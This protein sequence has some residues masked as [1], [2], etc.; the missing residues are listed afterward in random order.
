MNNPLIKHKGQLFSVDHVASAEYGTTN[1]G[2]ASIGIPYAAL[3]KIRTIDG[4]ELRFF[5]QAADTIWNF[6]CQQAL[7]AEKF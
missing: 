6:L 3:L 4:K 5:N 2:A 1:E 7:D